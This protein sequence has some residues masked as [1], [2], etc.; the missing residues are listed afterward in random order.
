MRLPTL[1]IGLTERFTRNTRKFQPC[2]HA[3]ARHPS[4]APRYDRARTYH[5]PSIERPKKRDSPFVKLF[6]KSSSETKLPTKVRY[7]DA[8]LIQLAIIPL[9]K[10]TTQT[11]YT[12]QQKTTTFS[13]L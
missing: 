9:L 12:I 4:R 2:R 1:K 8:L 13:L 6:V 10:L 11:S 3:R 7:N 5:I